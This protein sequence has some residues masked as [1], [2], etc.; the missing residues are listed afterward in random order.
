LKT[1]AQKAVLTTYKLELDWLFKVCPVLNTIPVFI[2]HGEDSLD[3]QKPV[4]QSIKL[5]KPRTNIS[6][7]INHGKIILLGNPTQINK[8]MNVKKMFLFI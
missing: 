8:N 1:G 2:S 4:P 5:S 3:L 7:S 6:Y